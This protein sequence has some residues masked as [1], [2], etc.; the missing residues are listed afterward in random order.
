M[1]A[2]FRHLLAVALLGALAPAWAEEGMWTPDRFPAAAV[3][4]RTGVRVDGAW[5]GHVEATSVRLS[6]G[7]SGAVVSAAGLLV[8]NQHCLIACLQALATP[9]HDPLAEGFLARAREDERP[10]PGLAAE[11]LESIEDVTA[12]VASAT[13]GLEGEVRTLARHAATATLERQRCKDRPDGH[14][15]VVELYQGA[16]FRL[17][18]YR[19]YEDVRLA[20]APE[21]A[22]A[23][24]GGDL[25]NYSYPRHCLDVAFLRLYEDGRPATRRD[26]LA[27]RSSAPQPGEPVFLAGHPAATSR[28]MTVAEL[29]MQRDWF[30]P[31][32]QLVRAELR[33]RLLQ[34]SATG[35][36]QARAATDALFDVE[37]HF[38]WFQGRSHALADA[39]F[40]GLL[41]ES[42]RALR[43]RVAAD[44]ALGRRTG[45]PWGEAAT[46]MRHYRAIFLRHEFLEARAGAISELYRDA[47]LL[48]RAA[49]ERTRPD[50]ERL[51]E[52]REARLAQLER[53]LLDAHP[54]YADVERIGL[55][56]WLSKAREYLGL[57]SA[58]VHALLGRDDPAALAARLVSGTRLADA[59]FRT[60]LWRGGEAAIQ[61]SDDPLIRYVRTIDPLARS[62]RGDYERDVAGPVAAAGERIARAR[63]AAYGDTVYPDATFSLR[64][65]FGR[66]AG[67]REGEHDIPSATTVGGL[68]ERASG[69]APFVL[70]A[71]WQATGSRLD[72]QL[73]LDFVASVDTVN[74]NS[75]APVLDSTGRLIGVAFDGNLASLGG[76]Y[77]YDGRRGRGVAVTAVAVRAA[78][79]TIYGMPAL[80]D[81][82]S[83]R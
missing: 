65:S 70:P 69:V 67:W 46:A 64:V 1:P 31:V 13:A 55:E 27:W 9:G 79:Y 71:R 32:R 49:R 75:G 21:F 61:A 35:P 12:D 25:D 5:L 43:A 68:Y 77:G 53:Q 24:F 20:F 37:N 62:I 48:V 36:E 82:L 73:P 76:E 7:C 23:F 59:E 60:A 15:E 54:F 34:Y 4:A 56:L 8:S 41:V 50:G 74:G 51:P 39:E 29:E 47:M 58:E 17:Y 2:L 52:Y 11:I 83:A 78:L 81:E 63:F 26:H 57:D 30:L 19:R 22:I 72:A 42:E 14:C 80:A 28:Q 33:G 3:A 38:K 40:L 45:D 18:R 16:Q 66:V 6:N 44:P 10:C